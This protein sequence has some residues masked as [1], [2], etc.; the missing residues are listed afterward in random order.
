MQLPLKHSV[1]IGVAAALA[2]AVGISHAASTTSAPPRQSDSTVRH[3]SG[4]MFDGNTVTT[5]ILAAKGELGQ[6][7][8]SCDHDGSGLGTGSVR[9]TTDNTSSSKDAL[10]FYSPSVPIAATW[11]QV[12]G[13][14]A[15]PWADAPG[16]NI[17]F[18][19]LLESQIGAS[20]TVPPTLTLIHGFVQHFGFG[21]CDYY[22]QVDTSDVASPQT[23]AH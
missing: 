11:T 17:V 8:L 1:A 10:M 5:P 7:S 15:F 13:S 19:M 21:G 9:F 16:D 4:F 18:Q 6:L 12:T 3:I 23:V 20:A 2:V 22:V 14:A